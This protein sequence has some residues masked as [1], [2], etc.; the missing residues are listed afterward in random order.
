[1]CKL[2]QNSLVY[3]KKYCTVAVFNNC[4]LIDLEKEIKLLISS[5]HTQTSDT[6]LLRK[7]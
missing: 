4:R 5:K 6:I 2:Q 7:K 1:M 3:K